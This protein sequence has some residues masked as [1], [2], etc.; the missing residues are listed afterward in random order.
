M[1]L[2]LPLNGK[3]RSRVVLIGIPREDWTAFTASTAR[4]KGLTIKLVRRMKHIYPQAIRLVEMGQVDV[5]SLVTH[6]FPF[7]RANE[8]FDT[9]SRREGIK[10]LITF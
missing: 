9:A 6:T 4:R 3:T 8:A 7:E 1:R 2:R 5:R 10:V